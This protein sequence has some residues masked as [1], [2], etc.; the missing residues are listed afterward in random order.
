M[1]K[2]KVF[3]IGPTES[4]LTKRGNRFPNIADYLVQQGDE[5]VYY[6]GNFYHAEKRFF[7]SKEI[8]EVKKYLKYKLIVLKTL[9]YYNNVSPRRVLNNFFFSFSM[10]FRL[11]FRTKKGDKVLLP[12]RP[13]ELIYFMSLLKRIKGVKIFLDI[14]DIW[15]DAL[16][17]KNKR[18]KK[19]FETYCNAYLKPSLK[20]YTN[21]IHTAPSF[22][23]W[24]RRYAQNTPST[25][26]PLGW[27]NRRWA[28][29]KKKTDTK[30]SLI[31]LVCVAQLQHQIDVMPI[32][33][34]LKDHKEFHL[35][36]IGEDGKGE[37]YPEVIKYITKHTIENVKIV[38]KVAREDMKNH[39]EK[40]EVGILPMITP[41]IPNK[42]FDYLAS[43]L[44][45]IVLGHNDSADFVVENNIGWSCGYNSSELLEVLKKLLIEGL[46]GKVDKLKE[47]RHR[48]S[49]DELHVRIR[50][51]MFE[52]FG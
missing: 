37:R 8:R 48:Y 15:P 7:S 46:E 42:I 32:L 9:G 11:L 25:F 22:K 47:V 6:T 24:L 12:S 21:T 28:N 39:L 29:F 17:I 13:V 49:R 30:S 43:E 34:V 36:I 45:I 41:S 27:E 14:Q 4:I 31:Q 23:D 52:N 18:K 40:M 51:L 2:G 26:I 20:Y 3:L 33:E 50:E 19:I 38:G 1:N 35:T 10:F 44:P 16:E 5:I